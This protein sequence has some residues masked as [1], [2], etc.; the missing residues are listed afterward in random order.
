MIF[1]ARQ[2][3]E[4]CQEMRNNLYTT[5]ADLKK[6]FDTVNRNGLWKIMQKIGCPER[7]THMVVNVVLVDSNCN[8]TLPCGSSKLDLS[9]SHTPDNRHDRLAK[10][11]EGLRCCLDG[12]SEQG[13]LEEVG[14]GYTFFWS[15]HPKTERR[16]AGVALVIRKDIVERLPCLPQGSSDGMMSLRLPLRGNKFTA[17]I[18]PHAPPPNAELRRGI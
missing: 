2:L 13:Q 1:A 4:K 15:G 17:I 12:L 3:Q 6:A 18:S 7:F 16:D 10:P 8:P 11:G 9:N 5:F 14:D